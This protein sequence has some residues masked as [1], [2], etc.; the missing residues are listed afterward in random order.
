MMKKIVSIITV[1]CFF[2]LSSLV[3]AD[4]VSKE[5]PYDVKQT[6]NTFEIT[7]PPNESLDIAYTESKSSMSRSGSLSGS[8]TVTVTLGSYEWFGWV[9]SANK[10]TDHLLQFSQS[11]SGK[12]DIEVYFA[13][14]LHA[15]HA[16]INTEVWEVFTPWN[17]GQVSVRINNNSFQT[18]TIQFHILDVFA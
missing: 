12:V 15:S 6:N 7:I 11:G 16:I 3:F 8:G 18:R 9:Y 17:V 4:T 1:F 5:N 10:W 13:G 2:S 14:S